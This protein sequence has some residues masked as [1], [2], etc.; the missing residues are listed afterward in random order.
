MAEGLVS[1]MGAWGAGKGGSEEAGGVAKPEGPGFQFQVP[2][3]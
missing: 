2:D 3:Y 1:G